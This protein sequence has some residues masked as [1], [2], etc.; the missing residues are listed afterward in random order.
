MQ[1][2]QRR[3]CLMAAT[4][5]A[6]AA[7]LAGQA[8]SVSG[9][10]RV[11]FCKQTPCVVGDTTNVIVSGTVVFADSSIDT[12]SWT[13]DP[14]RP[15]RSAGGFIRGDLN[16]CL[17]L[18]THR[19][20][21]LTYAGIG[22]PAL[23]RWQVN[24]D[25]T[26][27]AVLYQSPDAN[28]TV[29]FSRLDSVLTGVGVSSAF[30]GG[31]IR[32]DDDIVV[33]RRV[34]PADFS[35][36]RSA[37]ERERAIEAADPRVRRY[38]SGLPTP[39]DPQ[40]RYVFA[41]TDDSG[42]IGTPV[43][44]RPASATA[45]ASLSLGFR[46][47]P[48]G[49]SVIASGSARDVDSAVVEA[50]SRID[51]LRAQG[52]PPERIT[53]IGIGGGALIAGAVAVRASIALDYA[54]IGRCANAVSTPRVAPTRVLDIADAAAPPE[55]RCG[56]ALPATLRREIPLGHTVMSRRSDAWGDMLVTWMNAR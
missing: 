46:F 20:A 8:V 38:L 11:V 10:Y 53:V 25:S 7:P 51:S 36:C 32:K 43:A 28:A 29:R 21:E 41:F 54:F 48:P 18:T 30:I 5:C 50:L 47:A 52:V 45:L 13:D 26:V 27:T 4:L 42:R 55:T 2:H 16:G 49:M 24:D 56:R 12:S 17:D 15:V 39:I 33:G 34:G 6:S 31:P 1:L 23:F 3:A 44:A 40:R 37:V 9:T 22:S 35:L 14:R 19:I